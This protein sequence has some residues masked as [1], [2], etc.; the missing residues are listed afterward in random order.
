M[1]TIL[2]RLLEMA[3]NELKNTLLTYYNNDI[4]EYNKRVKVVKSQ[5]HAVERSR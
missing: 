1:G 4:I 5:D 2:D 3:D